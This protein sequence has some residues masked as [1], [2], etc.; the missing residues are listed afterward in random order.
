MCTANLQ[1]YKEAKRQRRHLSAFRYSCRA[2]SIIAHKVTLGAGA[3]L[4]RSTVSEAVESLLDALKRC[5]EIEGLLPEVWTSEGDMEL[6]LTHQI[7]P[8]AMQFLDEPGSSRQQT[9]AQRSAAEA[10]LSKTRCAGC[11]KEAQGLR[12]CSRC[13]RAGYC[14]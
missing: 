1:A 7:L 10:N 12:K 14:R 8:Q 6:A 13:R 2:V 9:A 4:E 11:G 3:E 5:K